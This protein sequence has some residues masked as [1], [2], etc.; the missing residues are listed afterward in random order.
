MTFAPPRPRSA[1]GDADD[2]GFAFAAMACDAQVR[3][4]GLPEAEAAV[5]AKLAVDEVRRIEA[6][7]S[8]Y[9]PDSI[10][11]RI[12]AQ[13]GSGTPVD[14]DTE[15]ADLL[16]FAATLF[17]AS[18]GLF[19]LTSGILRRAWDFRSQRV[20]LQAEVDALLPCVG[21]Q[22]VVWERERQGGRIA[23]TRAGMQLDFGGIGKEYAA[24]RAATLLQSHGVR[25][26]L[27][28][29]GGDIR[30]M[31]PRPDG[32]A[33]QL[34]V[35]HPRDPL[36]LSAQMSLYDGALATS[37]DYERF[38]ELDG[39]RYSHLLDP[40]TGW[41]VQAWQSV[42]V[43]APACLAAGALSTVAMLQGDGALPFLASQGVDYLAVDRLGVVH[44][45]ALPIHPTP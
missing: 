22:Q 43:V 17:S 4:G 7:Y 1:S 3:L 10:V 30:L 39:R 34:G 12:N 32:S 36:R 37:G 35:R 25:H 21:W 16:D 5:L 24:D 20:P 40:R 42:S 15:T 8:R 29:L 38:I 31:G 44:R 41:P 6:K 13:A 9:Q 27:V 23:L 26:G 28:N 2:L 18:G 45:A 33:W 19:D 14:V 11:S